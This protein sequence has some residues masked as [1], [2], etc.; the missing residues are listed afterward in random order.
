M[1]FRDY[2][3]LITSYFYEVLSVPIVNIST[4][5]IETPVQICIGHLLIVPIILGTF[6]ALF[7]PHRG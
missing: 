6:F 5:Y 1:I 7:I 4:P 2:V 3:M